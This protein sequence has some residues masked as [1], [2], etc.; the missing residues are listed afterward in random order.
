MNTNLGANIRNYRKNKGFTQDELASMLGV[1]PQAVSRWES[2]AGLPDV[3]MIVPIAQALGI[4]T[5]IL[6]GYNASVQDDYLADKIKEQLATM[7]NL[8]D[9]HGSKLRRAEY[10][11]AEANKNPMNFQIGIM[12]VQEIAG[13]SYYI[14]ME[15]LLSDNPKKADDILNDGIRKG[16]SII[17]YSGDLK[18][19]EKAHYA[20]SWIYI[21]KKDFAN[22]R[23][24]INVL[25]SL[26]SNRIKEIISSELV[27]FEHGFE[28]GFEYMKDSL[29]T[30]NQMLCSVIINQL[31]CLSE[32]YAYWGEKEE[33]LKNLEW[34]ERVIDAFAS[35]PEYAGVQAEHFRK[36]LN[37]NLMQVYDKAGEKEKADEICDK[38]LNSIKNGTTYSEAEYEEISKE[39][40]ERIYQL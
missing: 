28:H 33:A 6:L 15:G 19:T 34:C 21:H 18:L 22:A 39:F 29:T 26:E 11:A 40:R 2:E 3:S 36:K 8:S 14:D 24:H 25:P 31:H 17:R 9:I 38:Y 13:L 16:V 4:T 1:T 35:I 30:T 32:N 12:Y 5:D 20:L 7:N 10:L 27:F 37:H 23:E